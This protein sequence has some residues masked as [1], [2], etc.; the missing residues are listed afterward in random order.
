MRSSGGTFTKKCLFFPHQVRSGSPDQEAQPTRKAAF[1]SSRA[2]SILS[3]PQIAL[4][5]AGGLS[6]KRLKKARPCRPLSWYLGKAG[7]SRDLT[8]P[9]LQFNLRKHFFHSPHPNRVLYVIGQKGKSLSMFT[10]ES[11][12]SGYGRLTS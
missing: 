8:G 3:A 10:L 1:L 2:V 7:Q 5:L 4:F 6:R 12:V 9:I 11:V